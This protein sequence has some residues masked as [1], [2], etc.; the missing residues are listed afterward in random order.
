VAAIGVQLPCELRDE[1]LALWVEPAKFIQ[2]GFEMN[3][4]HHPEAPIELSN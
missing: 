4:H 3:H 1:M 2:E